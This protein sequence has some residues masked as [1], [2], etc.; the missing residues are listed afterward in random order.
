MARRLTGAPGEVWRVPH[1]RGDG[2][3]TRVGVPSYMACSPQAW[4]WPAIEDQNARLLAVFPTGVGM[5]RLGGAGRPC[6]PGVPHRRGDGPIF[7]LRLALLW[8]CSPQAWGWPEW[9]G[10]SLHGVFVFPTGVG[11][12]RTRHR[13]SAG[14][15]R[16]PHR[17]GDGPIYRALVSPLA[18]C[19]PQAWGW[20]TGTVATYRINYVFPTGVGMARSSR[21]ASPCTRSVPH[22]RGDGPAKHTPTALKG[23]CSPQAWGWP[24]TTG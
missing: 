21:A 18:K 14:R 1:R 9:A 3:S 23:S 17:R 12:A 22:R 4:G 6:R 19:S 15:A 2:P 7:L 8:V 20:P 13:R 16:V 5:A 24:V 10:H 11:M